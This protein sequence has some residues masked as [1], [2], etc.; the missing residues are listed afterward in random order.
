MPVMALSHRREI[1]GTP[2]TFSVYI[3]WFVRTPGQIPRSSWAPNT[4]KRANWRMDGMTLLGSE[5][6]FKNT[7][8]Y[9][10]TP[11][12]LN[13]LLFQMDTHQCKNLA[14]FFYTH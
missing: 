10:E 6:R 1:D 2:T 13:L 3:P 11:S 8:F 4:A 7:V 9:P 12:V 14:S 5:Y